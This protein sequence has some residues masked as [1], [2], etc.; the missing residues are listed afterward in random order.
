[1]HRSQSVFSGFWGTRESKL[2]HEFTG[3]DLSPHPLSPHPISPNIFSFSFNNIYVP[4]LVIVTI[5][6]SLFIPV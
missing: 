5:V 1:M 3:H 6:R 2:Y 4:V